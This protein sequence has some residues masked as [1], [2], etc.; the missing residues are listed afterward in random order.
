MSAGRRTA[1]IDLAAAAGKTIPDVIGPGLSVLFCGINPGLRSAAVGHHF[2]RPGNRFWKALAASGFTETVLS[3][4]DD[5]CLLNFGLGITNLVPFATRAAAE[6]DR[7][8]LRQGARDLSRKVSRWHPQAVAVLGLEA[9]RKGFEHPRSVV[10][11]QPEDLDGAQVWVLPN[12]SGIQAF[13]PFDRLVA[14]LRAV[15]AA[16][17]R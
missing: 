5:R 1:S 9:Y 7:S 10:G 4:Y 16:T 3:P 8:K 12:P 6:L 13:Y 11:R 2:A 17:E 14:E 15:R